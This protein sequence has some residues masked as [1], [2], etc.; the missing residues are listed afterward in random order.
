MLTRFHQFG[1]SLIALGLA[2]LSGCGGPTPGSVSGKVTYNG[3]S[4]NKPDGTIVFVGPSGK[5][6]LAQISPDGTYLA[7]GVEL[8]E[9]KVAVFYKNPN[10]VTA[11]A[12]GRKLPNPKAGADK[13]PQ[14]ASPFLTPADYSVPDTSKLTVTVQPETVYNPTLTGP[15][16][17]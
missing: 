6:A 5:Q 9:N 8:G 11:S 13:Q 15:P 16:I 2:T 14:T 7:S 1:I 17:K 12:S 4:L 10:A 3:S